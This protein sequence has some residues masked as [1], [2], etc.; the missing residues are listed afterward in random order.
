MKKRAEPEKVEKA[1]STSL[2]AQAATT[3]MVATTAN[4]NTPSESAR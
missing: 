2:G 4:E 3:T 1:I